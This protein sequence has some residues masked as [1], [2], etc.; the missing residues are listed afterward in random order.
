MAAV[1]ADAAG[2]AAAQSRAGRLMRALATRFDIDD[3]A[4]ASGRAAL[5]V[6]TIRC[7]GAAIAYGSQVALA[8]LLGVSEFGTY[9]LVWVW[10]LVL[11]HLSPLGFSQLVCRY[12]PFYHARG[13]A[14][15]V[16]GFLSAGT[17]IVCGASIA[18]ALL[19]GA[20][21]WLIRPHLSDAQLWAFAMGLGLVPLI[22]L[23]DLAENTAR[24]FNWPVLAIAPPFILRPALIALGVAALVWMGGPVEAWLAVGSTLAAVLLGLLLQA[25]LV[26]ARAH[27]L[28]GPSG[29]TWCVREWFRTA[30]PLVFVDG[31]HLIFSNVDILILS[32]FAGPETVAIYFAASRILQLVAF[33]QYAA[34]A[35]TAQRFSAYDSLGD[36]ARL[37]KLARYTTIFNVV[38]S[39]AAAVVVFWAAP[40]LL[41]M[42][43][44]G[45]DSGADI[46]TILVVGLVIQAAAGPGEDLL[47]MLGQQRACAAAFFA[48]LILNVALNLALI[49]IYGALGAAIATTLAT[50]VRSFA[51]AWLVKSRL[52]LDILIF[53][54]GWVRPS[55]N[56]R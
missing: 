8:R 42:F 32:F 45:F 33:G 19:G 13:D 1:E 36:K 15:L 28:I 21:L 22:A 43:G 17:V 53:L 10:V 47:N 9:A 37:R 24:A 4:L 30:L 44:K 31:T 25:A 39:A 7:A 54:P 40:L 38:V 35:A 2:V 26:V 3:E 56:S 16:R 55:P 50:G 51:L 29:Q 46:L 23:Q 12:V 52:G 48:A 6:L 41:G 14:P 49:P 18:L 27:A 34:T 20:V 11:G 5:Q